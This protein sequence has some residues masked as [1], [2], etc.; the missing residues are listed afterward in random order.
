MLQRVASAADGPRA[1]SQR[2]L[3][4]RTPGTN[5]PLP[6]G[7]ARP[8]PPLPASSPQVFPV[9]ELGGTP[10]VGDKHTFLLRRM[11]TP[12]GARTQGGTRRA[13]RAGGGC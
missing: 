5:R 2:H 1:R 11:Q 8:P 9:S 7:V 3:P 12:L 4:A 13:S 6:D 10:R